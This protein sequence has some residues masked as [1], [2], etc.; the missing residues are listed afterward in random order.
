MPGRVNDAN[1][2]IVSLVAKSPIMELNSKLMQTIDYFDRKK[3]IIIDIL[4]V[5]F[6]TNY[7]HKKIS[8]PLM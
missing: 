3:V 2:V 5:K 8:H 4:G 6:Y 1:M 7:D